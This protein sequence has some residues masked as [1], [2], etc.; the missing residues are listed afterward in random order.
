[1]L[2]GRGVQSQEWEIQLQG[3]SPNIPNTDLSDILSCPIRGAVRS[4]YI[5]PDAGESCGQVSGGPTAGPGSAAAVLCDLGQGIALLWSSLFP[6]VKGKRQGLGQLSPGSPLALTVGDF[7][8]PP[9]RGCQRSCGLG[10]GC[11]PAGTPLGAC[12]SCAIGFLGHISKPGPKMPGRAAGLP[13]IKG[14][15]QAGL[16]KTCSGQP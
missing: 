11:T 5:W 6:S 10:Q 16:R 14:V 8:P 3:K 13:Q 4:C 9:S 12:K 2:W 15:F 7:Q 1:M